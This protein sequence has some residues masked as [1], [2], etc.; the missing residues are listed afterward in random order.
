[1]E[2]WIKFSLHLL[3]PLQPVI[4]CRKHIVEIKKNEFE[5]SA[6]TY[7]SECISFEMGEKIIRFVVSLKVKSIK[8]V[9]F[10]C[11]FKRE[12]AECFRFQL[13]VILIRIENNEFRVCEFC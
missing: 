5:S 1:M 12:N 9:D 2:R 3:I 4:I 13:N 10:G 7:A 11:L 6:L 8:S